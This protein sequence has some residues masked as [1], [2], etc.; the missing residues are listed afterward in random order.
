MGE[1]WDHRSMHVTDNSQNTQP[2]SGRTNVSTVLP[3]GVKE[4]LFLE[5]ASEKTPTVFSLWTHCLPVK[6]RL[7][8]VDT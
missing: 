2:L 6:H 5:S 3:T 8:S 1:S 4:T 7:R